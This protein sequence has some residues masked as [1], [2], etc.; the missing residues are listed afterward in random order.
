MCGIAGFYGQYNQP[1]LEKMHHAINHRG[2]DGAGT[3]ILSSPHRIPI[4]LAHARLS[5]ID[6]SEFGHQPMTVKCAC[7]QNK[8]LGKHKQLWLIYNGEIYNYRRLRHDLERQGH[9]FHSNSDSEVL[10]HLYRQYGPDMLNKLNGIFAFALYDGGTGDLLIARDQLGVKPLYY[11][12][13]KA[14]VLFASELKA[15]LM[16]EAVSR[17][18]DATAID[19]YLTYLWCPAPKTMLRSVNKLQP[20]HAMIIRQGHIARHWQYYDIPSVEPLLKGSFDSIAID[21][22]HQIQQAV[23]RQ[24]VADVPIG[25]FLSGGLDSSSIVAMMKKLSPDQSIDCYTIK[26][27]MPKQD[28][29]I[30]DLPYAIKVAKQLGVN[31]HV[32]DAQPNMIQR[33]PEMLFYLDE[34][35]ADP[36]PINALLISEQ[37]R[38]DGLKVL[39]SGAGG[40]DLFTGYRRHV[41]LHYDRYWQYLPNAIKKYIANK[42]RSAASGNGVGMSRTMI[43]RLMKLFSYIDHTGDAYLASFFYWNT[44][45]LRQTLYSKSLL[46]KINTDNKGEPLLQ[47]LMSSNASDKVHRMLYLELKHFLADHNL[48]YTDRASMAAGIEVRVPLIDK[49]LVEFAMRIPQNYKQQGNISKAI[50]KKSMEPYLPKEVIYRPK[51]GFGVPLRYWMQN[52]LKEILHDCLSP[53]VIERRGLFSVSGVNRLIKL[54]Q[55]GK[56]DA[57]YTIFSILCIELWCRQFIDGKVPQKI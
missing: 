23:Q 36:A 6:L 3:L 40:D 29:F 44:A 34:P 46:D 50:F 38:R 56:L 8:S 48:N 35:Q 24:L 19:H 28:G 43:R 45:Q 27:A 53:D 16:C 41:A 21:L 52:D 32:V 30:D 26:T 39:M 22:S 2:P 47:S 33:L 14:G 12:E 37:A 49:K 55:K 51:T 5:I 20:G 18:L 13:T 17:E 25:A 1:L 10:I 57:S 31:L 54:N 4:G 15:I 11:S 7:C 42:A 9:T